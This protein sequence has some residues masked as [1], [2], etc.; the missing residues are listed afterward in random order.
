MLRVLQ[1]QKEGVEILQSSVN[2]SARQLM[3]MDRELDMM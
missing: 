1:K 2:E 3:V